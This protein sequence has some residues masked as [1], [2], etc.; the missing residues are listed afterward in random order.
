M[1]WAKIKKL[2]SKSCLILTD[3]K[4]TITSPSAD[5]VRLG[6]QIKVHVQVEQKN[7]KKIE[8]TPSW[9]IPSFKSLAQVWGKH[10]I[11]SQT[12]K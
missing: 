5:M 12:I 3:A 4:Y 9:C 1:Q 7:Q 2:S 8:L 6:V 11:S 10:P